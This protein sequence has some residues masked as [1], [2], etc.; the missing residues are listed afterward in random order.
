MRSNTSGRSPPKR[1]KMETSLQHCTNTK[2]R[3]FR[4]WPRYV[5]PTTGWVFGKNSNGRSS[6]PKIW[7][8]T[9]H[10]LPPMLQSRKA[11]KLPTT[12]TTTTTTTTTTKEFFDVIVP[13][14]VVPGQTFKIRAKGQEYFV[15]CPPNVTSGQRIRVPIILRND[16]NNNNNYMRRPASLSPVRL[17]TNLQPYV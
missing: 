16:H 2:P 14:G 17:H 6:R 11:K 3:R 15:E 5:P 13:N 1:T 9:R 12:I 4:P 10:S 7:F 8:V